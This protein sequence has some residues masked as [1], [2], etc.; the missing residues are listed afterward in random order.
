MHDHF[1]S[2]GRETNVRARIALAPLRRVASR[3]AAFLPAVEALVL[4]GSLELSN[5]LCKAKFERGTLRSSL[6]L[7]TPL[8]L[9]SSPQL[10]ETLTE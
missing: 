10:D 8:P 7:R 2:V 4:E 3:G 6:P 9:P 5:S 1:A